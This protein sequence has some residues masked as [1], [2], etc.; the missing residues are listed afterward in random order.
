LHTELAVMYLEAIEEDK[1][2]LA[3][4]VSRDKFRAHILKSEIVRFKYL[5]SRLE[6]SKASNDLHHERAILH[7]KVR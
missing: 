6:S 7:G 2:S 3:L 4:E 1:E 5:L